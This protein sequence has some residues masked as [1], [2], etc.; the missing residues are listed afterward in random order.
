MEKELLLNP[1][2]SMNYTGTKVTSRCFG[3]KVKERY[4][5]LRVNR[6]NFTDTLEVQISGGW[7][8]LADVTDVF[9]KRQFITMYNDV[10]VWSFILCNGS[11]LQIE[12]NLVVPIGEVGGFAVYEYYNG[13]VVYFRN[14]DMTVERRSLFHLGYYKKGS[15]YF[16]NDSGTYRVEVI[17]DEMPAR[18]FPVLIKPAPR[19]RWY[20]PFWKF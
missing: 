3:W 11:Y 1:K 14:K 10:C 4:D 9:Q 8:S 12:P 15:W 17:K 13:I 19:K 6:E 20:W 18:L 7:K 16:E 2:T 5:G